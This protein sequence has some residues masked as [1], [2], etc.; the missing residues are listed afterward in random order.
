MKNRIVRTLTSLMIYV[1]NCKIAVAEKRETLMLVQ[2]N[3]T[4]FYS[5]SNTSSNAGMM[6]LW[7]KFS[8]KLRYSDDTHMLVCV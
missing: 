2:N 8:Y 7:F 3:S 6:L 4:P 5:P 1:K